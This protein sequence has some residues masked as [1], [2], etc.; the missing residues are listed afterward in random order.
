MLGELSFFYV[1]RIDLESKLR[2]NDKNGGE[3]GHFLAK[4]PFTN[5]QTLTHQTS[6]FASLDTLSNFISTKIKKQT[7]CPQFKLAST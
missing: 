4:S 1:E 6:L 3:V 5:F 7:Y 2:K